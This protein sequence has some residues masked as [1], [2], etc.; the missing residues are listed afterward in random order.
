M[1][2]SCFINQRKPLTE[3]IVSRIAQPDLVQEATID[4]VNDF[5]MARQ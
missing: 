1:F 3:L 4:L 5:Q 2:A